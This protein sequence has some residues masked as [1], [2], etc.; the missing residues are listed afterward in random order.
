M[1]ITRWG[2]ARWW[3]S[4][5]AAAAVGLLRRLYGSS[6]MSL[7]APVKLGVHIAA[8]SKAALVANV[9][10]TTAPR[11]VC[12]LSVS[13]ETVPA[14]L[15]RLRTRSPPAVRPAVAHSWDSS[16]RELAFRGQLRGRRCEEGI[17]GI[18]D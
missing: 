7:G 1:R 5:A 12:Q 3:R 2:S 6:G 9:A 10:V 16:E 11:T 4:S 18:E 8:S 17:E 14:T 15:P 13:V